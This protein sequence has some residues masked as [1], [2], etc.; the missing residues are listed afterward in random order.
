[1]FSGLVLIFALAVSLDTNATTCVANKIFK[2]RHICGRVLDPTGVPIPS[3]EVELLDSN[4]SVLGKAITSE[5]GT[6]GMPNVSAGQYVIRVQF[7]GFATAWQ[8]FVLTESKANARCDKP[9]EVHLELL[10][11]CSSVSKS[12]WG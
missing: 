10:G 9:M 11:R 4:S 6:F 5:T 3:V 1:M 7:D 12:K 8:P 2:V